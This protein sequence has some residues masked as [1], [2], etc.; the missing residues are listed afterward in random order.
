MTFY[1]YGDLDMGRGYPVS[2]T[3]ATTTGLDPRTPCSAIQEINYLT[4]ATLGYMYRYVVSD[5][6]G[7]FFCKGVLELI[8]IKVRYEVHVGDISSIVI[9]Y[10]NDNEQ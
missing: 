8:Q 7:S 10:V 2:F 6:S 4:S 1:S 9:M 5:C 3:V